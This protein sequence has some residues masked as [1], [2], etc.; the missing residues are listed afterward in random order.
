MTETAEITFN[1]LLGSYRD[2]AP[3]RIDDAFHDLVGAVWTDGAAR[4]TAVS[5]VPELIDAL[6][7][8]DAD[9]RG[10]LLVLLGLLAEAEHPATDGPVTTAVREGLDGYLDAA[11]GTTEPDAPLTLALLYLLAHFPTDRARILA[12]TRHL[13]LDAPDRTRLERALDTL[14]EAD[15]NI[16]RAWPSPAEWNISEAE[17]EFDRRWIRALT[18]SQIRTTW[19]GDTRSV[20]ATMGAK[21]LWAQ[22]NGMPAAAVDPSPHNLV[23]DTNPRDLDP[24]AFERHREA[25]KCPACRGSLTF[26]TTV[27]RCGQ[28]DAAYGITH[29]VLDLSQ[30]LRPGAGKSDSSDDAEADVLQNAAVLAGIGFHYEQGMRPN[31]LRIMGR[32]WSGEVTPTDEDEYIAAHL[33]HRGGTVLDLAAAAGRWT[34]VVCEAV[35]TERVLALD[36]NEAMLYD[37]RSRLTEVPAV[38]G[39]ALDLP[40]PDASLDA[41]NFWN[42]L[43]AVPDAGRA[44]A[45]IGRCLRPGG[46]LTLMTFRWDDSPVYRYYQRSH[47]FPARPDGFVLFE[48]AEIKQWLDDAGLTIIAESYPGTFVFVTAERRPS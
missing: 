13:G 32:N 47:H 35:G 4:P 11:R 44:I 40:F 28:C 38:R 1:E 20:L 16:G 24:A 39:D 3:H 43:Q 8:V 9:R 46:T 26:D 42:A 21:A 10:Y 31:F 25:L 14:D 19:D 36:L 22:G 27:A 33:W 48:I 2:A 15:P 12:A 17:R 23:V 41:V 29:G 6:D 34:A 5:A 7:S 30:R 18:P 37:L 45:E